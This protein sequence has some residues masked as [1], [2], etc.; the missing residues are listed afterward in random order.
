MSDVMIGAQVARIG[1]T[2]GA[3]V[4]HSSSLSAPV[5]WGPFLS[6]GQVVRVGM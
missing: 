5:R 3:R 1:V 2:P 6:R 4:A